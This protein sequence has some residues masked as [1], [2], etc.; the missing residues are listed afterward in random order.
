[1]GFVK[2]VRLRASARMLI[3]TDFPIKTICAKIGYDSRS[4]FTHAFS[5]FFGSSPGKYRENNSTQ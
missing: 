5:E 2:E 4:H 3:Q 1:M